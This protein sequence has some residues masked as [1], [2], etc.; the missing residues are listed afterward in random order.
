MTLLGNGYR[1][2]STGRL[3]GATAV[4]GAN[5][6]VLE[7]RRHLTAQMRN[8]F[9]S[10]A[11]SNQLMSVPSGKRHPNVWVMPQV[12][13]SISSFRRGAIDLD[14]AA[15]GELG[16]PRAATAAM[17]LD[18]TAVGGL[19][20]GLTATAA[21]DFSAS[22]AV[23]GII[24]GT[25][26]FSATFDG[27]AAL[28]A[29]ASLTGTG[30]ADFSGGVDMY[31]I[32]YFTASTEN[33]AVGLTPANVGAAVWGAL[34]AAN[35]AAGTMGALMN[36]GAAGGLTTEQATQ[37][38]EIFQRLGLDPTKPLSQTAVEI[39]TADWSLEVSEAAGTVT[40][41]RQ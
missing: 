3:F 40:V 35:N 25:A 4:D 20:A 16:F 34:A 26:T 13:G 29:L 30:A 6:T 19:I 33:D 41:A 17:S 12:S 21:M 31:G 10:E 8:M 32:G 38:L 11:F 18:A 28:G 23:E 14:A 36:G 9:I 27:S 15:V 1:H 37:L 22:A 7:G 39:A 5:P 24:N 2:S